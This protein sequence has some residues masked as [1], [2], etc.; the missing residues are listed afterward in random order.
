MKNDI[1]KEAVDMVKRDVTAYED[2][3]AFVTEDVAFHIRSLIRKLRK[4]YWGIFEQQKDPVT[5]RDKI[6]VPLTQVTVDDA[7]KNYDL[8]QK[9]INF[10][11]KNPKGYEFTHLMRAMAIEQMDKMFFGEKLDEIELAT[12]IDGTGIWHITDAP[13]G[14]GRIV[15]IRLVDRLNA[16]IDT[17]APSIQEAYSFV[18]RAVLTPNAVQ[19]FKGAWDNV[20]AV[21][22]RKQVSMSDRNNTRDAGGA[23]AQFAEFFQREGTVPEYFITGNRSDKK[24]I[25]AR[26]IVSNP[27]DSPVVHLIEKLKN[28]LKEYEEN[29]CTR[30]PGRWDGRGTGEKILSLQ[31]WLNTVVNVRNNRNL[32]AQLGVLKIRKGS[33]ITT[34]KL[35]QMA[36]TG[37]VV[38][39][40]PDDVTQLIV[41]EAG[42]GSYND[43]QNIQ[44]WA[45]RV[46]STYEGQ[47]GEGLPASTPATNAAIQRTAGDSQFQKMREEF[48]MFL[49]RVF[50]RHIIPR[51]VDAMDVGDVLRF[52][53]DYGD[54]DGLVDTLAAYYVSAEYEKL[55]GANVIPT[56]IEV[57]QAIESAKLKLTQR[58]DLFIEVLKKA[59][60]EMCYT[61]VYVTNE[62]ID[63]NKLN[64]SLFNIL[65]IAPEYRDSTIAEIFDSLGLQ[66]PM[67]P[68]APAA[69]AAPAGAPAGAPQ[70][71][72]PSPIPAGGG[73]ALTKLA[74]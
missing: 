20:D 48:G 29:W 7:V 42:Q 54:F 72:V 44:S 63:T 51:I 23:S 67:K 18:E 11:A 71:A 57:Q 1:L 68:A 58:K 3:V 14:S 16:Y 6:W 70:G 34:A 19:G 2:S 39:Q 55:V 69:P 61:Q 65:K 37:S 5:G 64:D 15:D 62:E 53:N 22:Y 9:D 30:V 13:K 31:L 56:P 24:L 43:E 32:L 41:S 66:R 59:G 49:Q 73:Q 4:N 27:F 28:G 74:Q 10:R 52:S 38:V 40:N 12:N 36:A 17:T 33:G 60:H 26:I 25:E 50:D 35:Q 8:D 46:T 47:T 21:K 45:R